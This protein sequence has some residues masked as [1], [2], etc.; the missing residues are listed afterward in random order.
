MTTDAL[1]EWD[2]SQQ[3]TCTR[4][5]HKVGGI[6]DQQIFDVAAIGREAKAP[7]HVCWPF[8]LQ[9]AICKFAAR[10]T[11]GTDQNLKQGAR[12]D[13]DIDAGALLACPCKTKSG[14]ETVTAS[15]HAP[16]PGLTLEIF[17]RHMTRNTIRP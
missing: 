17:K 7:P 2:T 10:Q 4:N 12:T 9:R 16:I 6:V 1:D 5:W 13:D 8:Q 3:G 15:A 11:P 14:H